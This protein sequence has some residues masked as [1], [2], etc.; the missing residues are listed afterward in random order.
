MKKVT[1]YDAC[2][3]Q[4]SNEIL[5]SFRELGKKFSG[6]ESLAIN[7]T[8]GEVIVQKDVVVVVYETS[9]TKENDCVIIPKKW[10]IKIE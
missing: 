5:T 10:V 7:K 2:E 3:R 8:V 4:I 9:D 6:K 1:W